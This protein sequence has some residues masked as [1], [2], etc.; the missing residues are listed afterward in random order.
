MDWQIN[1]QMDWTPIDLE[2]NCMAKSPQIP[3]RVR[4]PKRQVVQLP[5]TLVKTFQLGI[6]FHQRGQLLEAR[7]LYQQV[8]EKQPKHFDSVHMLGVIASQ[9]KNHA[10]AVELIRKAIKIN[11]G[12]ASAYANLGAALRDL[13]RLDDALAS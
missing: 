10:L 8:L 1:L 4:S 11:P 7:A 13:K 6:I 3:N 5:P 9:T 12:F 2:K